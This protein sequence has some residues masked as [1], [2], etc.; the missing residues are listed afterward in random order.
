MKIHIKKQNTIFGINQYFKPGKAGSFT[1][2]LSILK[3]TGKPYTFES[4]KTEVFIMILKGSMEI[5]SEENGET[6]YFKRK[7]V[8]EDAPSG[9]YIP[10]GAKVTFQAHDESTEAAICFSS[11][12]YQGKNDNKSLHI[13]KKDFNDSTVKMVGS[14]N[15]KR[16]VTT[17]CGNND[18][19]HSLIVGETI[20]EGG[21]WSSYPPHRHEKNEMPKENKLKEIYYYRLNPV[22]GFAFQGIYS[23]VSG[24]DSAFIVRDSDAV[25]ISNG[26]HPV[27]AAPGYNLFYLWVLCG[28]I[29]AVSWKVDEKHEWIDKDK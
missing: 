24:T 11:E 27:S 19:T 21:M 7:S 20:S 23:E 15:Y 25:F 6:F 17:V 1:P 22:Q 2:G 14:G 18:N 8:F 9:L 28:Q 5:T 10:P 3:L 26:Y 4:Q 12:L 16:K 13:Y 29:P